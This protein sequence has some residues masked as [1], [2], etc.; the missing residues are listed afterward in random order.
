MSST[1]CKEACPCCDRLCNGKHLDGLHGVDPDD[2]WN[3]NQNGARAT[4]PMNNGRSRK[5]ADGS[6]FF[7]AHCDQCNSEHQVTNPSPEEEEARI[8]AGKY[9]LG[10]PILPCPKHKTTRAMNNWIH[11]IGCS[12]LPNA[13]TAETVLQV[14]DKLSRLHVDIGTHWFELTPG[15]ENDLLDILRRRRVER[16]GKSLV[17]QVTFTAPISTTNADDF[18]F[19]C[20]REAVRL[21]E[22]LPD[23]RARVLTY[24]QDR[25]GE[26]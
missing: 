3:A 21:L 8:D 10:H 18:E 22:A 11:V 19:N 13:K 20:L 14:N 9:S 17:H 24:L 1:T 26:R 16:G 25:Y 7:I 23:A 6:S 5:R 12:F 15:G 4:C 2:H